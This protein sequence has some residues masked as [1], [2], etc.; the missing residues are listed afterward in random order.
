MLEASGQ[1]LP[2][3]KPILEINIDHPLLKRLSDEADEKRFGDLSNI[4]LD[5]ALLADGTALTNPADYVQRMNKLL[6]EID[7][8]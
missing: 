4:V 3:S 5:H 8:S 6:L 2:D 7:S 1:A